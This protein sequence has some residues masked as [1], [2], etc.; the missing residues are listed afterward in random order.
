MLLALAL[1]IEDAAESRHAST[2]AGLQHLLVVLKERLMSRS[3]RQGTAWCH[4]AL[5]ALALLAV[6]PRP[7]A[8]QFDR[9]TVSGTV[10]DQQGGV[11]PGATVTIVNQSTR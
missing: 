10:T 9:G 6:A 3:P 1:P 4:L 2:D 11:V 8:A 7:A 5:A